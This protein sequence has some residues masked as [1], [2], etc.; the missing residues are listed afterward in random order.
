M[1]G[2]NSVSTRLQFAYTATTEG[3]KYGYSATI[4]GDKCGYSAG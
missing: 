1:H 2:F 4:D 3:D